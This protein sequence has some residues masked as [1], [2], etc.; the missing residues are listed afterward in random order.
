M[1]ILKEQIKKQI[2]PYIDKIRNYPHFSYIK[3][4]MQEA[5]GIIGYC[6]DDI[7]LLMLAFCRT[8]I[9]NEKGK[10]N[11]TYFSDTL[12][13]LGDSVLHMLLVEYFFAKGKDKQEINDCAEKLEKN[14]T[15]S[16]IR[17]KNKLT[18]YLY[19]ENCFYDT[20]PQYDQ[21]SISASGHEP[22]IEAII[23]AIY[24]DKGIDAAREWIIRHIIAPLPAV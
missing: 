14:E 6:F 10:N 8:K 20:A 16:N 17:E 1:E 11:E 2:A 12:A 24:L 15:L 5:Q 9:H 7:S 18:K 23:G 13:T 3:G 21:V 19:H 22:C 4:R